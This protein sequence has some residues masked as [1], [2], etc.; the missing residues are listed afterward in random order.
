MRL[1]LSVHKLLF[2]I[3]PFQFFSLSRFLAGFE[4]NLHISLQKL[5]YLLVVVCLRQQMHCLA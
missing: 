2:P 1:Q 5:V 4:T 3:K